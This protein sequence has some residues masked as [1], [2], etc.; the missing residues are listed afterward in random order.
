MSP[1]GEQILTLPSTAIIV[2]LNTGVFGTHAYVVACAQCSIYLY[3]FIEQ[4]FKS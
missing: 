1:M 3:Y 2:M 4:C